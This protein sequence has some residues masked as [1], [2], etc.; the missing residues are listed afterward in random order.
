LIGQFTGLRCS[1]KTI[2]SWVQRNWR[3]LI[4]QSVASY[5]VGRGFFLFDFALKED[6]DLI[7]KNEPYFMG[8]RGLYLNWW[9]PDFD[10]STNITDVGF[11]VGSYN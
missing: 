10:P 11:V 3:P 2:E 7:F 6:H 9:T 4:S 8:P 5:S 1:P